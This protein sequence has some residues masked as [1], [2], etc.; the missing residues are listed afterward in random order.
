MFLPAPLLCCLLSVAHPPVVRTNG[1]VQVSQAL[2]DLESSGPGQ[3]ISF[4]VDLREQLD[5]ERSARLLSEASLS[6]RGQREWVIGSLKA[7]ALRGQERLRPVLDELTHKGEVASWTGVS[8]VDRLVVKGRPAA[9]RALAQHPEVASLTGEIES[10]GALQIG[11]PAGASAAKE[12]ASWPLAAIGAEKA[13]LAGIDGRGV[14]VG[15]IDSGASHLH[16]QLRG[17]F[18]GGPQSWFDPLR[19]SPVPSDVQLGHGTA[20][21]SCAVGQGGA[22]AP[23]GV[24]P[25][26]NWIAAVGLHEGRYNNVLATLAADW[27]LNVGRP[28]VLIVPWRL[29]GQPCDESLRPIVNAWRA[30]EIVVVFAAGNSGPGPASDVAPANYSRLFPGSGTALSVGAVDRDRKAGAHSSRGPNRCGEGLFPQLVAP[31][32]DVPVALP[33][34]TDLYRQVSGTS[35]AAAY[36]AGASALLLQKFPEARVD[37][38]EDALR[39]GAIDLGPPG[40]DSEFGYGLINVPRAL[41]Y[42]EGHR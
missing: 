20:V 10:E 2:R 34:T 30:A 6:R 1:A 16:E 39:Q 13:W 19:R 8:I 3:P 27:M 11:A 7:I 24:A 41:G 29:L 40:P 12:L 32:A 23:C 26:A 28:D 14:T 42:L 35:F 25:G 17:N 31:G 4:L 5:F 22:G 21:L 38:I 33:A 9:I 37:R 18:R 36:V 15:L